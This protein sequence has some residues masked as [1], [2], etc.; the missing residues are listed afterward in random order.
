M[1]KYVSQVQDQIDNLEDLLKPILSEKESNSRP[2]KKTDNI[3]DKTET[4]VN[5]KLKDD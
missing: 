2:F 4:I 3:N 1:P 5:S